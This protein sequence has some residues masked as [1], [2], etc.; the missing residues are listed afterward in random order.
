[1][2][3]AAAKSS[4]S[5]A[6]GM[7]RDMASAMKSLK[8]ELFDT[9]Q[10]T[11]HE[12]KRELDVRAERLTSLRRDYE[13][14]LALVPGI[15]GDSRSPPP[16]AT[17][18]LPT[19][20]SSPSPHHRHR[21]VCDLRDRRES[22]SARAGGGAGVCAAARRARALYALARSSCTARTIW[23]LVPVRYSLA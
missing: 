3:A 23:H 14:A 16:T 22:A 7:S 17:P 13:I 12:Q 9:M 8:S 11:L 1:M 6:E 2:E 5:S 19:A 4:T 20:T 10:A 21:L 18:R 15:A